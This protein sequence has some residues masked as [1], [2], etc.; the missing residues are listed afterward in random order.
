MK[1]N[2]DTQ[3]VL[4]DWFQFT[5]IFDPDKQFEF[6][7]NFTYL[8]SLVV[9]FFKEVFNINGTLLDKKDKGINGYTQCYC[10]DEI[11]AYYNPNRLDMGINFKL[12]GKGCR[13]FDELGLNWFNFIDFLLTEHNDY[14]I[15]I[16]RVDIAIDDFT[17]DYFDLNKINEYI[18]RGKIV[19]KFRK[20]LD[21]ISRDL[22]KPKK[23][24]GAQ[25]QL[26]SKSSGV[27][28]TFYDKKLERINND[29]VVDPNIK[30]WIRTELRFRH[31]Y[32]LKV[33]ENIM[34]YNNDLNYTIKG[35]L[36]NYV[37]FIEFD[38][39]RKERC[40]TSL[41]W[42]DYLERVDKIKFNIKYKESDIT[43]KINWMDTS[44][45]KSNFMVLASMNNL[46]GVDEYVGDY[47]INFIKLGYEKIKTKDLDI[48]NT[49]RR[50]KG[51][52]PVTME[53]LEDMV[54]EYKEIYLNMYNI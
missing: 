12:S 8:D 26:G 15:M 14:K 9:S 42:L 41:W 36:H 27:E 24:Y 32:A 10:F 50:K 33:L 45:S 25:I 6:T 16:S 5:I 31:E 22:S 51:L 23:L 44:V 2:F 29:Y 11:E 1:A 53:E 46:I 54:K 35:V 4:F 47:L 18:L 17:N 21:M 49:Y 52:T 20:S 19:T 39:S 48:I 40:S 13:V 43:R 28:V 34:K 7:K 38:N 3:F 30:Y 37:R